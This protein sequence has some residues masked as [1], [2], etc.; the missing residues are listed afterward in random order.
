MNKIHRIRTGVFYGFLALLALLLSAI[1]LYFAVA[2]FWAMSWEMGL[3]GV[4]V[5]LVGACGSY[6]LATAVVEE[7]SLL[8]MEPK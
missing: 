6:L 2:Y 7:I 4:A 8:R 5:S 3:C 1:E